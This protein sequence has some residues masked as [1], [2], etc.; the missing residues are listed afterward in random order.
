VGL[1]QGLIYLVW[2]EHALVRHRKPHTR[3]GGRHNQE[4]FQSWHS[5]VARRSTGYAGDAELALLKGHAS[6]QSGETVANDE[7]SEPP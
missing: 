5:R 3:Y 4:D 6:L 2:M 1:F 7:L